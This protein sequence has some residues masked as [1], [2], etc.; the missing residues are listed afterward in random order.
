MRIQSKA[1]TVD[2]AVSL[3]GL[4]WGFSVSGQAGDGA[5][6]RAG[7]VTGAILATC[8]LTAEQTSQSFCLPFGVAADGGVYVNV[9]NT[10]D[11]A[12]AYYSN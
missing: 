6:F 5:E 8:L 3:G 7:S 10:P 2:G 9:I 4:F 12:V 1:V 11:V